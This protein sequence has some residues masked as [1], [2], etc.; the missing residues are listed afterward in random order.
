MTF[1]SEFIINTPKGPRKIGVGYPCFIVAELSANHGGELS[2][3]LEVV[4]AAAKAGAD[5]IK[6]QTYTADS[7]TLNSDKEAFIVKNKDNPE[8]WKGQTLYSLYEKAYTPWDWHAILKKRAEELGL[9]FFSTPFSLKDADKLATLD[10]PMYKVASY[11]ATDIPLLKQVAAKDKPIIMSVGFASEEEI[12]YSVKV[13]EDVG[14]KDLVI[15]HCVTAYS[16][17]PDY[18]QL[19]LSTMWDIHHKYNVISGFSDNNGGIKVPIQAAIMGAAIIEKHV[20]ASREDAV[21]DK[22]FSIDMEEFAEMVK[23]IRLAEQISGKVVYGCQNEKEEQNKKYRRSLWAAKEIM[24]GEIFSSENVRVVRP[25]IG[26][27]EPKYYELVLGKIAARRIEFAE[28]ITEEDVVDFQIAKNNYVSGI[29][30][31]KA[32]EKDCKNLFDWRCDPVT[33]SFSPGLAPTFEGH[34]DWFA[35]SLVNSNREILIIEN[36][37]LNSLGT[38]RFDVMPKHESLIQGK[39]IVVISININPAFRGR[40][41]GKKSLNLAINYARDNLAVNIIQADIM[42]DNSVSVKLFKSS[43]FYQYFKDIDNPNKELLSFLY[44]CDLE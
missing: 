18:H 29:S 35:K 27:L 1:S 26:G 23:Q 7:L 38:V 21:L 41:V 3:A 40:G 24:E 9:V 30:F 32:E 15:L 16:R 43:G 34:K 42:P 4:E 8:E 28:P 36:N 39:K 10:V 11:E 20:V 31:R 5:A 22:N 19:N 14:C 6:V 17:N 33:D 2:K 12:D 44:L 37:D 25:S 13:L